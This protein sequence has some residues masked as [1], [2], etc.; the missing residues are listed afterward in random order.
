MRKLNFTLIAL[1]GLLA[2]GLAFAQEA[3]SEAPDLGAWFGSTA[4]LSAIVVAVV[5]FLKS[6]VLKSLHDLATV[7]VS[8][9]VGVAL[10]VVGHLAGYLTGGLFSAVTF[11]LSAG[12]LASGGFDAITALLKRPGSTE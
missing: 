6:H 1:L 11:G 9:A 10:G 8:L 7:A 4:A 3:V 2:L 12:F 5:A